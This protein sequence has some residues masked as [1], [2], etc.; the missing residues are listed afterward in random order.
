MSLIKLD[1][2]VEKLRPHVTERAKDQGF[3]LTPRGK[4][5]V[6]KTN[7]S[8]PPKQHDNVKARKELFRQ[9]KKQHKGGNV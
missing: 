6:K 2:I 9:K 7:K 4:T 5:L 1:E 3:H 8:T